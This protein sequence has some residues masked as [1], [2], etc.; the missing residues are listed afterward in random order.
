MIPKLMLFPLLF[1]AGFLYLRTTLTHV[2]LAF[3]IL[4]DFQHSN[5]FCSGKFTSVNGQ[6][7]FICPFIH[8]MNA[9]FS[10]PSTILNAGDKMVGGKMSPLFFGH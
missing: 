10:L 9:T 1:Q 3:L 5:I 4:Q 7:L 8:L 2:S 6:L